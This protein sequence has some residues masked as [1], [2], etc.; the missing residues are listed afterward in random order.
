METILHISTP[1]LFEAARSSGEYR[2][3][4]LDSEGFIHCSTAAQIARSANRFYPG[5]RGLILLHIDPDKLRPDLKWEPADNDL[6]PHIYGPL[7]LDAVVHV[8]PFEP[9][10]DGQWSYP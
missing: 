10:P 1:E 4:S 5:Q 3:D 7:N 9:G 8:E 6:F 2:A